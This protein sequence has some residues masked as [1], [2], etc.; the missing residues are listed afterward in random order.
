MPFDYENAERDILDAGGDPDY[1]SYTNPTERD[2]YLRK[3]GL[4]PEEYGG[5]M[6][7]PKVRAQANGTSPQAGSTGCL[8]VLMIGALQIAAVGYLLK[9]IATLLAKL[10][11]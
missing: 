9:P 2:N 3:M 6:R 11:L 1:L 5:G 8:V 4:R 10:I 7:D